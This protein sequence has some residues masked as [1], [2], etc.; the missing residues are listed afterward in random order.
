VIRQAYAPAVQGW[1]L[2]AAPRCA[3]AFR[4]PRIFAAAQ[5]QELRRVVAYTPGLLSA[6]MSER[7]AAGGVP[8]VP[9]PL[10][11]QASAC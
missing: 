8:P 9:M 3:E 6:D 7:A 2:H 11:L 10:L 5:A 1:Q 4:V